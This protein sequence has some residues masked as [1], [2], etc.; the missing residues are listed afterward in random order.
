MSLVFEQV[1]YTYAPL[2]KKQIK[3]GQNPSWALKDLNFEINDGEFLSI[4]GHTGSGK[5]TLIQHL[6]GLIHPT[7]GKVLWNGQD[8]TNK[9]VAAKAREN[10]GVVFQ[11]PEKQLFGQTVKED[12]GFGPRNLGLSETEIDERVKIGLRDAEL[13]YDSIADLSPFDLSGGQQRR[14]SF[15]GVLAM[16]PKVLVLDEPVAGLDPKSRNDFLSLIESLHKNKDLTVIMVSHNMNDIARLSDRVLVLNQ[17]SIVYLDTPDV[18]FSHSEELK[19]INLGLP[20]AQRMANELRELGIP[21]EKKLY[22]PISLADSLCE[23]LKTKDN[24]ESQPIA[25]E[26]A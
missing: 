21:L 3:R 18:V 5:S 4:A 15:A 20:H 25:K 24:R 26:G 23:L 13:D 6:N 10:I 1:S 7:K 9:K 14:V 2:T 11:Y 19:K 17:G 22:S 12:V 16:Y 8:L